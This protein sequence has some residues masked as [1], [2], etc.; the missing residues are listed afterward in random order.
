MGPGGSRGIV[1]WIT[2]PLQLFPP[3]D[4]VFHKTKCLGLRG[5]SGLCILFICFEGNSADSHREE[6]KNRNKKLLEGEKASVLVSEGCHSKVPQT[7]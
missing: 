1:A 4:L 6:A 7:R 3:G 5:S 2:S